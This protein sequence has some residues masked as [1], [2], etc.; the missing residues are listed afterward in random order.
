MHKQR[1]ALLL[2]AFFGAL[3]IRFTTWATTQKPNEDGVSVEQVIE[4]GKYD[5]G[6]N[7]HLA[8]LLIALI[9]ILAPGKKLLAGARQK[10]WL[11]L[12]AIVGVLSL[13]ASPWIVHT[14]FADGKTIE[15]TV[16]FSDTTLGMQSLVLLAGLAALGGLAGFRGLQAPLKL[17]TAGIGIALLATS[18]LSMRLHEE[19]P[20]TNLASFAM[21]AEGSADS[22][23]AIVENSKQSGTFLQ[24]AVTA[25][26]EKPAAEQL[27]AAKSFLQAKVDSIQPEVD[28]ITAKMDVEDISEADFETLNV[29]WEK[30][31][32][33]QSIIQSSLTALE[34]ASQALQPPA[35][36]PGETALVGEKAD[37]SE[38]SLVIENTDT[39]SND[40]IVQRATDALQTQVKE[41]QATVDAQLAEAERIRGMKAADW[42][43]WWPK[44]AMVPGPNGQMQ[45]TITPG[46]TFEAHGWGHYLLML[47]G[48][49]TLAVLALTPTRQ[50][51]SDEST[52]SH[53]LDQS[54]HVVGKLIVMGL[55]LWMVYTAV[56]S[57]G[58]HTMDDKAEVQSSIGHY[59][60][61]FAGLLAIAASQVLKKGSVSIAT[62]QRWEVGAFGLILAM[63]MLGASYTTTIE[64]IGT[65]GFPTLKTPEE[66]VALAGGLFLFVGVLVVRRNS[67]FGWLDGLFF[68]GVICAVLGN[69]L[70]RGVD[71]VV[72]KTDLP[73][74]QMLALVLPAMALVALWPI[75]PIER[76]WKNR[77]AESPESS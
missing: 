72:A 67:E 7:I 1:L 26:K 25:S 34:S 8:L 10:P 43:D 27:A 52:N 13:F 33:R 46:K 63:T 69:N 6:R 65:I 70:F 22:L 39:P 61:L 60:A 17:L 12:I 59:L 47:L 49:L 77:E 32:G 19:D 23:K 21:E 18:F 4:L 71:I 51:T 11:V 15:D 42:E 30:A 53:R 58:T 75:E 66:M 24:E 45:S 62:S 68:T 38:G 40:A 9:A 48:V 50:N 31:S 74:S 55:G 29:A 28:E 36:I 56:Q 35:G 5:A 41:A 73:L 57:M 76:F 64:S 2:I 37:I 20:Q 54:M 14:S 16:S 3:S 44:E